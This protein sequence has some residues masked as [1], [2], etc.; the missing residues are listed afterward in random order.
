MFRWVTDRESAACHPLIEISFQSLIFTRCCYRQMRCWENWLISTLPTHTG[1]DLSETA[2]SSSCWISTGLQES[3]EGTL[4]QPRCGYAIMG[5]CMCPN[6]SRRIHYMYV[7]FYINYTSIN[8]KKTT[9]WADTMFIL[10]LQREDPRI[11]GHLRA[12]RPSDTSPLVEG[13]LEFSQLLKSKFIQENRVRPCYKCH[14][15]L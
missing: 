6:S 9:L 12:T 8:L 14:F 7:T 11:V 4:T 1:L 2:L 5:L 15:W 10:T 13:S 3:A